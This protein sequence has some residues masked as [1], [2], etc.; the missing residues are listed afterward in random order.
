MVKCGQ[1]LVGALQSQQ[2]LMK[3]KSV[4]ILFTLLVAE[5]AFGESLE[6][7]WIHQRKF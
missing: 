5:F 7:A 1:D 3:Q 6:R 4:L 2:V